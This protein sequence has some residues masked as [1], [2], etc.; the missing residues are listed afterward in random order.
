MAEKPSFVAPLIPAAIGFAAGRL[1]GMTNLLSWQTAWI[2]G[3]LG[4]A[5]VVLHQVRLW[6][7]RRSERH[8]RAEADARKAA[9]MAGQIVQE[10]R[11]DH[12]KGLHAEVE[13]KGGSRNCL[14]TIKRYDAWRADQ[15]PDGLLCGE[16]VK[17]NFG[18]YPHDKSQFER[19]FPD[20]LQDAETG[21]RPGEHD[22]FSETANKAISELALEF[23]KRL[24]F[25][26]PP[27]GDSERSLKTSEK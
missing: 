16:C 6:E 5:L 27:P 3:A 20:S 19:K 15:F 24:A 8:I 23:K 1:A 4:I 2:L 7:W 21:L 12:E 26:A 10:R 25:V 9:D 13:C 22:A 18:E 17:K 14:R 11:L